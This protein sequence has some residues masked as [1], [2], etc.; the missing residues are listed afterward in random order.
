MTYMLAICL[1]IL[2]E[3]GLASLAVF[4]FHSVWTGDSFCRRFTQNVLLALLA[5]LF[6]LT[7]TEIAFKLFFIQ[8]DGINFTLA[9][10]NWFERY[11]RPI[12]SLGYRDDEWTPEKIGSRRRI[13]VIGD[14]FVA[15]GGIKRVEDRFSNQLGERLD[16]DYAVMT[17]AQNGWNTRQEIDG[18]LAYPYL[19]DIVVF[20]YCLNDI[21]GVASAMGFSRPANLLTY[22]PDWLRPL[23]DNSYALNF[24][25]WRLFRWRAFTDPNQ[26]AETQSYQDHLRALYENPEVWTAHQNELHEVYNLAQTHRFQLIV[27]V[28]PDMLRAEKTH[29]LSGNVVHFFQDLGI[30]VVDVTALLAAEQPKRLVVNSVDSHPSVEVHTLV[31]NALSAVIRE[32]EHSNGK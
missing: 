14:S 32:L 16:D 30:P 26:R 13:V 25:Y 12:N 6:T 28:F 21:E 17:V 23:V 31:A 24:V 22:P 18:L 11:W 1:I 10:R 20:S 4:V 2:V 29:D 7:A 3:L 9:S 8:S 27:V 15:G 19:P 5:L